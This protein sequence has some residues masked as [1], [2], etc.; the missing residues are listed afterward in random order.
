ML[1]TPRH[2]FFS[3]DAG[4]LIT[5]GPL[6]VDP[7]LPMNIVE[8]AEADVGHGV[9]MGAVVRADPRPSYRTFIIPSSTDNS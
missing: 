4:A 3:L 9:L 8:D 1:F 2:D 7:E 6:L 5:G